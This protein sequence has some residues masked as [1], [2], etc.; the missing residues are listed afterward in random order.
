MGEQMD[1]NKKDKKRKCC[2]DIVIFILAILTSFVIG[3]L[4]GAFTTLVDTLGVGA[5]VSIL[6][7]FAVLFILRI[8]DLICF[9][10]CKC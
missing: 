1:C 4:V 6:V 7:T 3:I 8:V 2:L 5:I 9:K 10:K